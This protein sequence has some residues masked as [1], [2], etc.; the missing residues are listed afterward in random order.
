MQLDFEKAV[1]R[2]ELHPRDEK[3]RFTKKYGWKAIR[4]GSK[5]VAKSGVEGKV[6]K[7]TDTHYHIQRP[8]GKISRIKKEN[9]VHA[10]DYKKVTETKKQ[11]KKAS[12]KKKATASK[13]KT[14]TTK[15]AT[16]SKTKTATKKKATEK[17]TTKTTKKTT[18]TKT[19]ETKAAP[20]DIRTDAQKNR[21]LAYDVG[22]KIG[23]ARKD[24]YLD[25][26]KVKPNLSN[27]EKLEQLGGAVAE[28]FVTKDYIIPKYDPYTDYKNG[29]ELEVSLLKKLIMD[30]VAPKPLENTPEARKAYVTSL[31][32]LQR[33]FAGIKKWETMRDAIRE[34]SLL[35]RHIE[36]GKNAERQIERWKNNPGMYSYFNEDHYKKDL[37][38]GKEALAQMNFD[39][40]GEKL[41]RF[42]SDWESRDR[43]L[44]TVLKNSV[45]GWDKYIEKIEGK[46]KKKPRKNDRVVWERMTEAEHLRRGGRDIKLNKPEELMTTFG[47][48]AVEFGH[49]VDDTSGKYH[50][51]RCGEA[52]T[53]LADVLGIDEKDVSL[54]GRLAIAFGARGKGGKRSAMAHYEPDRKVINLTKIFGAGSLAHEWGHALDNLM[55]Q[56]SDGRDTIGFASEGEMGDADP[57]LKELYA[58]LMSA[59]KKPAPGTKGGTKKI[60][61]DSS[62][63]QVT[64]YYPEMRK[65]VRDGWKPEAVYEYWVNKIGGPYDRKI[66]QIK[67]NSI[68]DEK[69]KEDAIKRTET[70]KRRAIN[71]IRHYLAYE[72]QLKQNNYEYGGPPYKG[73]LEVPSG[74]SEFFDRM[75]EQDGGRQ[76]YWATEKEMFARVFEAYVQQKLEDQGRYNN[77]L[78]HSTRESD[79]KKFNAPFP[80]GKE[81][82]YMFQAM[83]KLINYIAK[84]KALKKALEMDLQK[85]HNVGLPLAESG[86]ILEKERNAYRVDW[87]KGYDPD[88]VLYIPVNRLRTPYQTDAALDWDKVVEYIN[89]MHR[90]EPIEPLVIGYDYDIHDGHHKFEASKSMNYTHVPCVVMRGTNDIERTRAI[91]AYKEVWKSWNE[92]DH[93]RDELGR[94]TFKNKGDQRRSKDNAMKE[95]EKQTETNKPK[96]TP[97]HPF[98]TVYHI[99]DDPDIRFDPT[100]NPNGQEWGKGFYVTPAKDVSYWHRARQDFGTGQRRKYVR[101]LDISEA[102]LIQP[103]EIPNDYERAQALIKHFGG[104]TKALEALEREEKEN[105]TGET[106]NM[107]PH[108]IAEYRLYAKIHGYD[109]ILAFDD[110]EGHQIILFDDK[111][112]RYGP[113]ITIDDFLRKYR[114]GEIK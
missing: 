39:P 86:H 14:T 77:Y 60:A 36:Y 46:K 49:W 10:D 35:A 67:A 3:G 103:H 52:L 112:V 68:I 11:T 53:D 72:L 59:I 61:L 30:R 71:E 48:R 89:C 70:R 16:V 44:R 107:R 34:F 88:E 12:A 81:R 45:G 73:T 24:Q 42:F 91:E 20:K 21:K 13:A 33:H 84:Q 80:I 18:T 2:E 75:L 9:V 23:G 55:K 93:P 108:E 51:Q 92:A 25:N 62:E 98:P 78:V 7:V 1:W 58:D 110:K 28:R 101:Q 4:T 79:A 8:D 82:K 104:S 97:N 27:L 32:K 41:V 96:A 17:K 57:K 40:L 50:L 106:Y 76:S 37:E 85:A 87:S 111:K 100:Y 90:G 114:W 15:K 56:Y 26:W 22:E 31:L 113:T 64:R 99:T 109:G 66:A 38:R 19:K 43:T 105:V 69:R 94:F 29:V 6:V 47:L 83:E 74:N 95:S 63:K 54:N 5:V 102:R 65:Q